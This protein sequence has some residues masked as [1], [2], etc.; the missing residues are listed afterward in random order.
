VNRG[1][2][3]PERIRAALSHVSPDLP[4]EEW[5][6]VAM[7]LKAEL[8]EAGFALFDDWSKSGASYDAKAARATWRSVK[9][10]GGITI[11]TLFDMAKAGG[12]R[13]EEAQPK[14]LSPEERKRLEA[15]RQAR[16]LAERRARAAEQ[17]TAAERAMA[18]WEAAA[19]EGRSEYLERKGVGVHG[20]RFAEGGAL[21]VPLRD[22]AGELWNVQRIAPDGE[23]RFER[24]GRVMAL[25][26]WIGPDTAEAAIVCEGYATG[27]TLHEASGLP[28]AIAFHAG[29]VPKVAGALRR[30]FP[31]L[32]L[33]IAA[34]DDHETAARTGRNPGREAARQAA[35]RAG[36][37]EIAPEGME[38]EGTDF[39]DLARQRGAEAVRSTVAEGVERAR[40]VLAE[41][42]ARRKRAPAGT[43]SGNRGGSNGGDPGAPSGGEPGE[44]RF[45]LD[46]DGVWYLDRDRDGNTRPLWICSPLT[47]EALTEGDTTDGK[48]YLLAFPDQRERPKR[49]AMPARMFGGDGAE[50]RAIL[51]DMG[52]RI[53]TSVRARAQLA[54]YIQTRRVQ[55]FA[56]CVERIGWHAGG[57]YVW[58]ERTFGDAGEPVIFQ[59]E[60]RIRNPFRERGTLE[61]WRREVAALCV[62]NS[63]LVFG[64]AAAFAGP[65]LAPAGMEGGGF[66]FR[67]PSSSGKTTALRVA[68]S[69]YGGADYMQTWRNT[70]NALEKVAE[71]FCDA[72]LAL[73]EI[74][75]LDSKET[76]DAAYMLANGQAKG[77]LSRAAAMRPRPTWRVLFVST[78]EAALGDMLAEAKKSAH[79]GHEV[80]LVDLPSEAG[81]GLGVFEELHGEAGGAVFAERIGRAARR[82]YG[83]AGAAFVAQLVAEREAV[84]KALRA[85][86]EELR[87]AWV[88]QAD[89]SGQ[90]RRVAARFAI[91]AA[92]GELATRW[93]ITGWRE[94]EA[95]DA[96]RA[97]FEAWCE[98]RGGR[99]DG[100]EIGIIRH[101]AGVLAERGEANFPWWHRAADDHRA[102][103]PNRWGLRKLLDR[104][105]QGVESNAD[106]YARYGEGEIQPAAAEATS[107]EFCILTEPFRREVCKGF[108]PRHVARVLA[109]RGHLVAGEGGRADRKE[110]LPGIGVA[111]C[112][113]VKPSIFEDE[114]L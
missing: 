36:A 91:V 44:D 20:V 54:A 56:R 60:E 39:N 79:A 70:A 34:D 74:R 2:H 80:R 16:E 82:Y 100:E 6:R 67:G 64:V 84:S 31:A 75:Q 46:G 94:A 88:A 76:G 5:V 14:R 61:E 83:T 19:T 43:G 110:R 66:H 3:G 105:G 85:R 108:D 35:E 93:G 28:V 106:Y 29:N 65:C 92:A 81:R 112:Y 89:T 77:R 42:D 17:R 97:L 18:G 87:R 8:G 24:G 107:A 55:T 111:R 9:S 99:L 90:V 32:P 23:K 101:V 50:Y 102:N 47:V 11:G 73:D 37:A 4:R 12:F 96:A 98:G 62:G 57:V 33:V 114:L 53:G 48:G 49:W 10:G 59:A 109:R 25:W 71:H 1:A 41:R 63:R 104:A 27:A 21:L 58:P 72:L 26:H 95:V 22:S 7:A 45:R 15:E 38:G 69:V 113:R 52:L 103:A 78:G 13:F 51:L 86:V 68:A 30:K 40:A